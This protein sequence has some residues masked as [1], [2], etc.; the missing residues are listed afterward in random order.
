MKFRLLL[1][2]GLLVTQLPLCFAQC[3]GFH[4]T[5]RCVEKHS[6]DFKQYGQARSA[7]V[8]VGKKYKSQIVLYG[9]KDYIISVCTEVGYKSIHFKVFDKTNNK[10][11]YDNEEDNYNSGVAFSM[12]STANVEIE[13]QIVSE[14]DE[15]VDPESYR[16]CMGIQI[17]WRKIPRLGFEK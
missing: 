7:A 1:V 3:Q 14:R 2:I 6:S 13:A 11:I 16:V 4:R 8:E 9:Q 15:G 17:L 10:L 5:S 12:E